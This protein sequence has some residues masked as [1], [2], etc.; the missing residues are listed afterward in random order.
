[1]IAAIGHKSRGM[2]MK[3]LIYERM[4]GADTERVGI[5][6]YR[7]DRGFIAERVLVQRDS[8]TLVQ[9]LPVASKDD[10]DEFVR[11]DPHRLVMMPMYR[12]VLNIIWKN[13][14]G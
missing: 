4:V 6:L 12:E 1:V 7:V 14:E 10:F 2:K 13:D 8:T 3:S 9:I 5:K 11:A